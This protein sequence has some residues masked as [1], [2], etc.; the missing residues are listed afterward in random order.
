M[1]QYSRGGRKV[2]LFRRTHPDGVETQGLPGDGFWSELWG[3][4]EKVANSGAS[5]P[6]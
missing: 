3:L 2:K 5:A 4:R 6:P 1:A